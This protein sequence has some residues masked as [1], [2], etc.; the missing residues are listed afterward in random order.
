M[1]NLHLCYQE[2][3][4]LEYARPTAIFVPTWNRGD[5]VFQEARQQGAE[6]LEYHNPV[7]CRS[8][9]PSQLWRDFYM[10]DPAIV[11]RWLDPNGVPRGNYAENGVPL[12]QLLDI[13]P[14]SPWVEHAIGYL[15]ERMES[16]QTDGFFL[17]VIGGKLWSTLAAFNT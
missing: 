14:G 6:V 3:P 7:E 17:D 10:G 15:C 13:R 5:P 1:N 2:A 9:S 11:P 12:T 4:P 16:G 8:T